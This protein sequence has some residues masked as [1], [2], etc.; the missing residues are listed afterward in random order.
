MSNRIEN[1]FEEQ[2]ECISLKWGDVYGEPWHLILNYPR[3]NTLSKSKVIHCSF[4]PPPHPKIDKK[5]NLLLTWLAST[6]YKDRQCRPM[7]TI[8][9]PLQKTRSS[10]HNCQ[11]CNKSFCAANEYCTGNETK[12]IG[13]QCQ[14]D[15]IHSPFQLSLF[16]CE[17]YGYHTACSRAG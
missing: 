4:K 13:M 6:E 2:I 10:S 12:L 17:V 16:I 14:L 3:Q 11:S 7:K 1:N 9:V 8:F 15:L 5:E